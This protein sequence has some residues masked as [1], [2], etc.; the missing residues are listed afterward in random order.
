MNQIVE[1]NIS[2][3]L[4]KFYLSNNNLVKNSKLII[5]ELIDTY[6][7]IDSLYKEI[8]D[9]KDSN[10][11]LKEQNKNLNNKYKQLIYDNLE[12]SSKLS[13]IE[14]NN[15]DLE[16]A[17]KSS[18]QF[19]KTK[20]K[21]IENYYNITNKEF[22]LKDAIIDDFKKYSEKLEN[23]LK[24]LNCKICLNNQCNMVFIPC[25]HIVTCSDC[26]NNLRENKCPVCMHNIEN[27]QDLFF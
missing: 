23:K 4:E 21:T 14:V 19:I 16:M 26:Y 17:L 15:Y 12:N 18:K 5:G 24:V 6:N 7:K 11:T 9:L 1:S 27:K 22:E 8:D 3:M 25:G 10:T 13:D 20:T 2:N